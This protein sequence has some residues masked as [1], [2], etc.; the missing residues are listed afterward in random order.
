MNLGQFCPSEELLTL[1]LRQLAPEPPQYYMGGRRPRRQGQHNGHIQ[2]PS[3]LTL[4]EPSGLRHR[5]QPA[6]QWAGGPVEGV[7]R[8]GARGVGAGFG[9]GKGWLVGDG[10]A[11]LSWHAPT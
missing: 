8:A 6:A 5:G 7:R 2:S 4:Q 1:A 11:K 3:R 9:E 10:F